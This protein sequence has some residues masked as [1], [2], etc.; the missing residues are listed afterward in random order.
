VVQRLSVTVVRLLAIAVPL[1]FTWEMLQAPAFTG[2]AGRLACR[3]AR[4]RGCHGGGRRHRPA[5]V[6]AGCA[7]VSRSP[8]VSGAFEQL[9]RPP[10]TCSG[11]QVAPASLELLPADLATGVP[12]S[13]HLEGQRHGRAA[14]AGSP[15]TR[16]PNRP[17]RGSRPRR[18]RRTAS[19]RASPTSCPRLRPPHP[20]AHGPCP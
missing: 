15:A 5:A 19:S 20:A 4:L 2:M 6:R 13:K 12:L 11:G 16:C 9:I 8:L 10:H 3:H 17:R 18:R 14:V 1:Y 7:D